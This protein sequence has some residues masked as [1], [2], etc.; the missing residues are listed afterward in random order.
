MIRTGRGRKV[1]HKSENL[2]EIHLKCKIVL[3]I[4][5]KAHLRSTDSHL[6]MHAERRLWVGP[7]LKIFKAVVP[8]SGTAAFF[9]VLNLRETDSERRCETKKK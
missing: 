3:A 6:A 8:F 7:G 1:G 4:G 9:I 2:P 5:T